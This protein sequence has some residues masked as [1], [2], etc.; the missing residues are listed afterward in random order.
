MKPHQLLAQL[1]ARIALLTGV[2]I[3]IAIAGT[4]V[5]AAVIVKYTLAPS[6]SGSTRSDP[7]EI[8]DGIT[9]AKYLAHGDT[10]I[11]SSSH[12][13]RVDSVD[14]DDGIPYSTKLATIESA[15]QYNMYGEFGVTVDDGM[16]LNLSSLE[17]GMRN[18]R[19]VFGQFFSVHVRS[20][21]DDFASDIATATQI[22]TAAD[23]DTTQ[24]PD[25]TLVHLTDADYQQL[26]G[27]VTFRLYMVTSIVDNTGSSEYIRIM[28]DIVLEG[29]ASPIPEP[30]MLGLAGL[31]GLLMLRRRQA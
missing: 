13:I 3:V 17:F 26:T 5:D 10:Q 2:G 24:G 30:A 7:T 16:M 29:E 18:D 4:P 27:T 6:V 28:P 31:G 9:A 1:P 22:R 15:V 11:G 8:H 23:T 25:R 20:S 14:P 19:G 12:F 21:L